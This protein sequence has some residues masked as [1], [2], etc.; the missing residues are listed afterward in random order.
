[1]AP[2]RIDGRDYGFPS[3]I[4]SLGLALLTLALG[5]LPLDTKGGFWSILHCVRDLAPPALPDGEK[6]SN[7][8]RDFIARCLTQEPSQRGTCAELLAHPF[9][10]KAFIDPE[11]QANDDRGLHELRAVVLALYEHV[12]KM[13]AC[14]ETSVVLD[15]CRDKERD[16]D[17]MDTFYRILFAESRHASEGE[18]RERAGLMP[19]ARLSILADQLHMPVDRVVEA[20]KAVF[21]EIE[22]DRKNRVS[23]FSVTP[24]AQHGLPKGVFGTP[25]STIKKCVTDKKAPK[26]SPL[27]S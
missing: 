4:W 23:S 7:E 27:L 13:E 16:L 18:H 25:S 5:R 12:L 8:F 21:A 9:L 10:Q 11:S 6:W 14:G 1:M 15:M 22:L 24:K 2:E 17:I 3:D 20:A 19:S 26:L